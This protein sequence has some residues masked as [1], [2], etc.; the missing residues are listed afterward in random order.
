MEREGLAIIFGTEKARHF[1][2]AKK[3]TLRTDH[4]PLQYLL[5]IRQS[6]N[7]RLV[8]WAIKLSYFLPFEVQH[9]KGELNHLSDHLS[10][11]CAGAAA[12]PGEGGDNQTPASLPSPPASTSHSG[13]PA[14][15]TA[16]AR[17]TSAPTA[18]V[19]RVRCGRPP[20][21]EDRADRAP[22]HALPPYEEPMLWNR[23]HLRA[24]QL[25]DSECAEWLR[26]VEE[27]DGQ[28]EGFATDTHGALVKEIEGRQRTVIPPRIRQFVLE[29][30]HC[31]PL[32]GHHGTQKMV[33]QMA[34]A[35]WW[36]SMKQDA[37]AFY[38]NCILCCKRRAGP[39]LKP[40]KLN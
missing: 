21:S 6:E 34:Q 22:A 36:K 25:Q 13:S 27:Q 4:A 1:L 7:S 23:P 14:D 24:E 9:I 28:W 40:T 10:R 39:R 38:D 2:V 31:N 32:S 5:G 16:T 26:L 29:L 8:R 37:D 11:H 15:S 33:Q 3:W 18:A 35:V 19:R 30:F 20:R 12:M 17:M